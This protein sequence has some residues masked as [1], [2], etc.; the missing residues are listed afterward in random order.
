M[1]ARL[2]AENVSFVNP[3]WGSNLRKEIIGDFAWALKPLAMMSPALP[4][5]NKSLYEIFHEVLGEIPG[6]KLWLI[7]YDCKTLMQ[8]LSCFQIS[9]LEIN[10]SKPT[11]EA[12]LCIIHA[13]GLPGRLG[14]KPAIVNLE[15]IGH[16]GCN[17]ARP[18]W[19]CLRPC[20][21]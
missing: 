4:V 2:P 1:G 11:S 14:G 6:S 8:Y 17:H 16:S 5:H 12:D 20:N 18:P 9:R 3:L 19:T 10:C 7:V 15:G 13:S 21:H